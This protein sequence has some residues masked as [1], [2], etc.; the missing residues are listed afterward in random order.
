[1]GQVVGAGRTEWAT[2][3]SG[4]AVFEMPSAITVS[5]ARLIFHGRG[6]QS[7][8]SQAEQFA[9]KSCGLVMHRSR[10]AGFA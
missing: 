9:F 1:M 8:L 5:A 3:E 10:T 4:R 6:T 7:L 2:Q